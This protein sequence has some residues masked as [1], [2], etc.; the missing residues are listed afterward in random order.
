V[1]VR[2]TERLLRNHFPKV[3]DKNLEEV[4]TDDVTVVTDRL[5]KKG[6]AG[7]ANHSFTAIR[8][9]LR[10]CVKRRYIYHSPIE[11]IERPAKA[12]SRERVLTDEELRTVWQAADGLGGH[13]GAIV[14]L[15]ILTGQRRTEIGHLQAS[16]VTEHQICLPKEITKNNRQHP[17]PIG[18][19][20]AAILSSNITSSTTVIF[21]ARGKPDQPFNGRSKSKLLFDQKAKIAPGTLHDLRRTYATNLQRLGI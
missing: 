6:Q 19:L 2:D 10:W 14:K 21:P 18:A 13:F 5:L 7:A 17:F 9:F 15:L 11:G 16:Y 8:T 12:A 20:S 4:T 3:L 1:T